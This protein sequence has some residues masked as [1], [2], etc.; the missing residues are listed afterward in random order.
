MADD[1]PDIDLAGFR[2]YGTA[3]GIRQ[4]CPMCGSKS[5]L[6]NIEQDG[7]SYTWFFLK[8]KNTDLRQSPIAFVFNVYC[9]NC[10]FVA[11]FNRKK[12]DDWR[13]QRS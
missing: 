9:D 3:K 1:D 7:R 8:R 12:I 4:D 13:R 2:E 11:P 10:G 5:W 6:I